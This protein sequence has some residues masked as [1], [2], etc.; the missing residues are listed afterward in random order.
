MQSS[1]LQN[2][3]S[4]QL[5]TY[6]T[7]GITLSNKI[8][9]WNGEKCRHWKFKHWYSEEH[10]PLTV[11]NF[12]K[13]VDTVHEGKKLY[14][15]QL[16]A[17]VFGSRQGRSHHVLSIHE[18]FAYKCLLCDK[19]VTKIKKSLITHIITIHEVQEP[20]IA[21]HFIRG[22]FEIVPEQNGLVAD[23]KKYPCLV[24]DKKLKNRRCQLGHMKGSHMKDV[25]NK[26]LPIL[27]F[28]IS[29]SK[30]ENQTYIRIIWSESHSSVKQCTIC[31]EKFADKRKLDKNR[32]LVHEETIHLCSLC[33]KKCPDSHSLKIY[34]TSCQRSEPKR[35]KLEC[36]ICKETFETLKLRI[37]HWH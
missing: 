3:L 35:N 32:F 6:D 29:N 27:W 18:G 15:C 34:V 31:E 16:C 26:N 33:G 23:L 28:Y 13:E 8:F 14:P 4:R 25:H 19:V 2:Y 36:D 1:R 17:L 24:C 22:Q 30:S 20:Q 7:Q 9:V 5:W 11:K 10:D 12:K 21:V 37:E